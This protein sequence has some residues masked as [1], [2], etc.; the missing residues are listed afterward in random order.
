VRTLVTNVGARMPARVL[1]IGASHHRAGRQDVGHSDN[2]WADGGS[3]TR[4]TAGR[5]G[6]RVRRNATRILLLLWCLRQQNIC[7]GPVSSPALT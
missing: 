4:S 5:P 3:N 2:G 6:Q 7:F 1:M